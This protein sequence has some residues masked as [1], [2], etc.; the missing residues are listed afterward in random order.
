MH[1]LISQNLWHKKKSL[2]WIND[3]IFHS[4]DTTYLINPSIYILMSNR[5]KSRSRH[6]SLQKLFLNRFTDGN[7]WWMRN[8]E[9]KTLDENVV[10]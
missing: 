7:P 4:S 6:N 9:M 5:R 3:T 8:L 1:F 10:A 2:I